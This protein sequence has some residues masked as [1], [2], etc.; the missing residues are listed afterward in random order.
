VYTIISAVNSSSK[1]ISISNVCKY[2]L[3]IVVPLLIVLF[4]FNSLSTNKNF[5]EKVQGKVQS[6]LNLADRV[7]Y[8]NNLIDYYNGIKLLD[9]NFYSDQAQIHLEEVKD[10][11]TAAKIILAMNIIITLCLITIL[12]HEKKYETIF[13]HLYHAGLICLAFFLILG[14]GMAKYFDSLFLAMHKVLFADSL[15][16]FPPSDTLIQVFP[17]EFFVLFAKQLAINTI[18]TS[19]VLIVLSFVGKYVFKKRLLSS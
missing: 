4:N 3:L 12:A 11:L 1:Q 16:L 7:N 10:L 9:V 18:I 6:N 14:I 13:I 2:L 17:G 19:V 5:L 15:W 8:T